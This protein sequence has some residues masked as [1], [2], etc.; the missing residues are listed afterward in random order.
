MKN[1][2]V[3]GATAIATTLALVGCAA[4]P[5]EPVPP[6]TDPVAGTVPEGVL[7]GHTLT[8][9]GDGGTTQDGMM[10]AWFTPFA[11][12]SGATFQQD[13]PQTMAKVESQVNSGNIQWD[14]TSGY[15]DTIARG[16]GSYFEVLDRA[17]LDLSGIP[18]S[19][20]VL[21]CGVPS[22]V[23]G[24]TIVHNTEVFGSAGPRSWADFFDVQAFPGKRTF[25]NGDGSIDAPIVQGA[26]VAAGWDPKTPFTEEWANKGLDKI[27]SIA[28]HVVFY[29]TGAAAQQLLESGE[30]VM[31]AVWSGRAL[32]A[33]RNGAP[34]APSWDEWVAVV[35]YFAIVKGSPNAEAAYYAINYALGAEQQA[36]FTEATG[37]SPAHVDAKPQVDETTSS[38]LVTEAGRA[39]TAIP[40]DDAFW[41]DTE[42][43]LPLQDRWSAIVAGA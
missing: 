4:G 19:V 23:Y 8:F 22:I 18:E 5:A 35:D 29:G 12:A 40:L 14:L 25:Y 26:A 3:L 20:P 6:V 21:E 1:M 39:E 13:S 42:R 16:C 30:A 15:A 43:I 38:Y 32:A 34:I 10:S 33:Q 2:L 17:K 31:G 9:A 37:Y 36:A 41:A 11:E 27:A 28:D 7:A 24:V